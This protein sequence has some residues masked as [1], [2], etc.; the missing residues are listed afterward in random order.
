MI[1][2]RPIALFLYPY[3]MNSSLLIVALRNRSLYLPDSVVLKPLPV[4]ERTL[5]FAAHL[6]KLGYMLSQEALEAVNSLSE[7]ELW[8][9]ANLRG[10]DL[11]PVGAVV[12]AEPGIYLPGR[13]G[14]RIEDVMILEE[15]GCEVI[16]KAPK[17]FI[18]VNNG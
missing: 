2:S 4:C 18:I 11:M 3:V 1:P 9:N 12:S 8:P 16:T 7:S 5:S 17:D 13:F 10:A 15:G 14:V 6:A